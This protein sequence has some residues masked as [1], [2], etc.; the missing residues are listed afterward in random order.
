MQPARPTCPPRCI[1][2]KRLVI[3]IITF[4]Q[5]C[6]A[7]LGARSL[8][9]QLL[10][11]TEVAHHMLSTA[12]PLLGIGIKIMQRALELLATLHNLTRLYCFV[13]NK[14]KINYKMKCVL[15]RI[16]G[17]CI[18]LIDLVVGY[19]IYYIIITQ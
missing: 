8:A 19:W 1:A 6:V 5:Q 14:R 9:P 16:K 17:A 4:C 3:F 18:V 2:Q 13:N 10:A 7:A 15:Y 11:L 12:A